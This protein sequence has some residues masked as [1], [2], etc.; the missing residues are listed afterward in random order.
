MHNVKFTDLTKIIV[1]VMVV[2]VVVVVVYN[3]NVTML[4]EK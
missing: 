1:V 3:I 4:K 2:V